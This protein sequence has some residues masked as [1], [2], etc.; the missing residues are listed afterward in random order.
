[1]F[2]GVYLDANLLKG[3]GLNSSFLNGLIRILFFQRAGSESTFLQGSESA[4]FQSVLNGSIFLTGLDTYIRISM[5]GS[6]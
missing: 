5:V 1:M 3:V 6:G 2:K 4:H